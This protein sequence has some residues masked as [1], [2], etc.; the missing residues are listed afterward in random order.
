M[1]ARPEGSKTLRN[2]ASHSSAFS[3]LHATDFPRGPW[4]TTAAEEIVFEHF[5][6]PIAFFGG[7][8][9]DGEPRSGPSHVCVRDPCLCLGLQ[10]V[11]PTV[12]NAVGKLF[13][14]RR[15][16]RSGNSPSKSLSDGFLLQ[17]PWA[18]HFGVRVQIHGVVDEFS[19]EERHAGFDAPNHHAFV[20]TGTIVFVQVKDFANR[21]LM[22]FLRVG[23]HVEIEVSAEQFVRAF[24]A[25]DH[26]DAHGTNPSGHEVHGGGGA[27]GGDVVSFD[28]SDDVAQG[29]N[30]LLDRV[31]DSVV[32]GSN[33]F[34][35]LSGG[36]EVWA[37]FQP[38]GEAVHVGPPGRG[39]VVFV[40]PT[41]GVLH[42]QR[43]PRTNP[44][45][46]K[47]T[48]RREHHPSSATARRRR[49]RRAVPEGTY[50]FFGCVSHAIRVL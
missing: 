50:G 37:A 43:Q 46:Q 38:D 12:A 28:L 26:L 42:G 35:N 24:A 9:I 34:G 17:A 49:V 6:V 44:N 18:R 25:Q 30:A 1:T 2:R 45:R 23:R 11:D 32:G 48:A 13:F 7:R 21:F 14:C 3:V 27:N 31:G 29:V 20:G 39:V 47:S 33:E 8:G 41:L 40:N 5:T 4:R 19:I 16:M 22:E 36:S 15:K 10:R